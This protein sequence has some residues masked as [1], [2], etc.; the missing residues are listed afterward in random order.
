[1]DHTQVTGSCY[2]CHNGTIATGKN[3]GHVASSNTCESCHT[4]TAWRPAR[5]DH[6]GVV[7]GTCATCHNGVQSTGKPTSH[8]PT[9]ASCDSCHT[10]VAWTPARFDHTGVTGGCAACHNGTAATGKDAGHMITTRECIVCHSTTA[11]TPLTFRHT[12]PNY[13]GDH[14]VA[15][16][17]LSCHTSNS[18]QVVWRTPAYANSCAG[19]HASRYSS[20]P[21]TKIA[22]PS[23]RYTVSELRNCSGAC[24]IYTDS[25][26]TTIS[27]NRPGPQHRVTNAGFN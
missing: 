19:C 22:S 11:W 1:V 20:E 5:F 16:T 21:H 3:A 26:L 27:R 25:T 9:T 7:A 8:V 14:R 24:H 12:S 2:S 13:P 4:T 10:T 15:L 23:T 6:S 17:C 18:D